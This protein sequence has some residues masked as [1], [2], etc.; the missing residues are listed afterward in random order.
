MT[1]ALL[2]CEHFAMRLA[3]RGIT[4][5][6]VVS[7]AAAASAEIR[8]YEDDLADG[9]P[10]VIVEV[11]RGD[12]ARRIPPEYAACP[13]APNPSNTVF[14]IGFT[15]GYAYVPASPEGVRSDGGA[16]AGAD[17]GA[18]LYGLEYQGT[19]VFLYTLPAG[20]CATGERV[21]AQPVGHPNLESLAYSCH[22]GFLYSVAFDTEAHAGYLIRIDPATGIGAPV[23]EER[24]PRDVWVVGLA[25]NAAAGSFYG[26]TQGFASR[27]PALFQI[28]PS[29]RA[30]L[31]GPTGTGSSVL[32]S[33]VY[34][35]DG[36]LLA[37]GRRL[38]EI[39]AA[40]GMGSPVGSLEFSGTLWA[41]ASRDLNC[42]AVRTPTVPISPAPTDTPQR[43][44]ATPSAA[45][46]ATATPRRTAVTT[47][48]IGPT[49]T[50]IRV[51][52]VSSL[53][54][55]G[56]MQIGDEIIRYDG[57]Q[58]IGA[59]T[60]GLGAPVPGM[61]LN[62]QRGV[63]GTTP[64]EHAAGSVLVLLAA[65][66]AGDCNGDGAVAINELVSGVSIALGNAA[67][68]ACRAMDGDSDSAV[69][70]SELIQAVNA[71][72]GGCA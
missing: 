41:L 51:D 54:E 13:A 27:D 9:V 24:M 19:D 23:G 17:L 12:G 50:T 68:D 33:L 10:A 61:L 26:V 57:I 37:G 60:A 70:I 4:I 56:T 62:V 25:Y 58:V 49:D 1:V 28:T 36:R 30:E 21:G 16:S 22:D 44:T 69:S 31:L 46:T 45:P 65:G 39:D 63:D 8:G 14:G 5:V 2:A 15:S 6:S 55:R 59:S 38:Y 52:D 20:M 7:L 11:D 35:V 53:P 48:R 43:V 3:W 66:C 32:Q 47:G 18:V 71:A 72:L 42:A 40:T 34:A 67:V 29:G 64:A